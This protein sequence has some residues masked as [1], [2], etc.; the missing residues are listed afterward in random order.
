M[1][2]SAKILY[3]LPPFVCL[4]V[5][6]L[7]ALYFPITLVFSAFYFNLFIF[8]FVSH[9]SRSLKGADEM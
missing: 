7:V 1:I 6:Y 3:V 2:T 5:F 8:I 4:F 9:W